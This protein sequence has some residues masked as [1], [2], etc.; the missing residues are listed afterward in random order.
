MI[1]EEIIASFR[2][3]NLLVIKKIGIASPLEKI[4]KL[5]LL[6]KSIIYPKI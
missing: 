3:Y 4:I 6:G 1:I 5:S 2:L